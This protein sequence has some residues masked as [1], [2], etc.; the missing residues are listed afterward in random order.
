VNGL[1]VSRGVDVTE[2]RVGRG[3]DA[4]G[5]GAAPGMTIEPGEPRT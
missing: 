4:R 3:R 5:I 1:L 2:S